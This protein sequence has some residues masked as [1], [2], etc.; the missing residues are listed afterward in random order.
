MGRLSA[1]LLTLLMLAAPTAAYQ[2]VPMPVLETRHGARQ[3]IVDGRPFLILGGELANS[4]ASSR[5][6]MRPVWPR[7][8]TM[9]LTP[10]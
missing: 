2:R 9:S 7:L 10:C 4:S 3:L 1:I 6:Y 5:D 8:R